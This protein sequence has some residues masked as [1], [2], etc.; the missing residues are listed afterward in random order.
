MIHAGL[1]EDVYKTCKD[2]Y[3]GIIYFDFGWSSDGPMQVMFYLI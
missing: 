2:T 1:K 3:K